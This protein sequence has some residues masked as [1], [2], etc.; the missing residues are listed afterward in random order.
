MWLKSVEKHKKIIGIQKETLGKIDR[1]SLK[2]HWNALQRTLEIE[3]KAQKSINEPMERIRKALKI[4][5]PCLF[6]KQQKSWQLVPLPPQIIKKC[7]WNN[8]NSDFSEI[9]FLQHL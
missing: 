5:R 3:A 7:P 4:Q 1:T 2:I 9:W 6:P 8:D